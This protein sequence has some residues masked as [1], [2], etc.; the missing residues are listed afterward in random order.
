MFSASRYYGWPNSFILINKTTESF[1][2]AK[3]IET[4]NLINLTKNDWKI[5]FKAN[6]FGQ[7]GLTPIAM[8]NL[9]INYILYLI[10]ASLIVKCFNYFCKNKF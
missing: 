5:T 4:E 9:I 8:L 7:Y 1:D 2:E 10:L 3:K 6:E